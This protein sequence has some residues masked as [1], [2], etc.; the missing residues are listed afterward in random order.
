MFD[1]A[2]S[3]TSRSGGVIGP[4]AILQLEDPVRTVLGP[5]VLAEVLDL[6][7][8]AMPTGQKMIPEQEVAAVH[9][10]L[11]RLYPL[12]NRRIAELS[13][14]GTARYIRANRIPPLARKG[15]RILPVW[16]AERVLTK[17]ILAH[18]WTFCGSGSVTARRL[19]RGVEFAL[20]NNPLADPSAPE[21]LQ[22]HWHSAVFAELYSSLLGTAY[23]AHEVA[24]C[25]SG[26]S[27]CRFRVQ[28]H[29]NRRRAGP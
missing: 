14:Q 15:L 13:G 19:S 21:R 24:C 8:V 6:C 18:A 27:A 20:A 3:V 23:L 29:P 17:A 9:H 12:Q 16:I 4:N 11:R 28:H 5:G 1:Q 10:M 7:G 22:C 2:A 25:G 26:A